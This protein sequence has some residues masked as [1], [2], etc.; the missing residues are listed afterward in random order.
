MLAQ[1]CGREFELLAQTYYALA[2]LGIVYVAH[3]SPVAQSFLAKGAK[4]KV[5]V[6]AFAQA[7][8]GSC[9]V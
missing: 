6:L 8:Y 3:A 2:D 5:F 1:K 9:C 4:P 7:I